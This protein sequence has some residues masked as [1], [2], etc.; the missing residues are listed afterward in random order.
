MNLRKGMGSSYL[1][2]WLAGSLAFA[3]TPP[4][5]PGGVPARGPDDRSL[6][7]GATP[8]PAPVNPAPPPPATPPIAYRL[9]PQAIRGLQASGTA[10]DPARLADRDTGTAF[11]FSGTASLAFDLEA[12]TSIIGIRLFGQPNVTMSIYYSNGQEWQP[13]PGLRSLGP[14]VLAP[15][16]NSLIAGAAVMTSSVRIDFTTVVPSA[17]EQIPEVEI[18]GFGALPVTPASADALGRIPIDRL[19]AQ[20]KAFAADP[21]E[22]SVGPDPASVSVDIPVPPARFRRAFLAYELDGLSTWTAVGRSINDFAPIGGVVDTPS[23]DWSTQVERINPDWLLQG[24]NRITFSAAD[25]T[26]PYRV[27][28]VRILAELDTGT[29]GV[30]SAAAGQDADVDRSQNAAVDGNLDTAWEPFAASAAPGARVALTLTFDRATWST[31]LAILL[32]RVPSGSLEVRTLADDGGVVVVGSRNGADLRAGWNILPLEA[33]AATRRM[34]VVFQMAPG[35][36]W[37]VLELVPVGSGIGSRENPPSIDVAWPV[38]GQFAGR[39]A[40]IRGFVSPA[41]DGSGP[42]RVTVG[43]TLVGG[44]RDGS[45]GVLVNKDDLGFVTDDDDTPW[46]VDIQAVYPS[47]TTLTRTVRLNRPVPGPHSVDGQLLGPRTF[48]VQPDK[49]RKIRY[50]GAGLDLDAGSVTHPQDLTITPMKKDDL[51][52]LDTG[53]TNV[54]KSPRRGYRFEPHGMRFAKSI[55]VTVPYDPALI[56]DGM[57]EKD[58]QTFYFDDQAGRWVPLDRVSLDTSAK[59]VTSLTDHFTDMISGTL[60]LPDHLQSLSYD[61][62]TMKKVQPANPASRIVLIEP[63]KAMNTGDAH[64]GYDLDLP[65]GRSGMNPH[66]SVT[67]SSSEGNGWLGLGWNLASPS[68]SIDTRWG[69]PRYDAGLETE[70]YILEGEQL[71]P[72]AHRGALVARAPEKTF[73]Y[74]TEGRFPRII[75]HGDAP[76]NYWWEATDTHGI[77]SAYG[78]DPATGSVDPGSTLA[79]DQGRIYRWFLH[80]VHDVHGNG[81]AYAY[82][83]VDDP[84]IVGGTVPGRQ[85]YLQTINYTTFGG[86]P[87]AFTVRMIR[88][89]DLGEPRRPDVQIDARGGFKMVTS[90]LLRRIEVTF[91]GAM[92][93]SWDLDYTRGAYEKSLLA[94]LTQRGSDGSALA[95]HRFSY[96]DDVREN[97]AYQGFAPVETWNTGSDGVR[98]AAVDDVASTFGSDAGKATALSG[99]ESTHVGGHLYVGFNYADPAKQGSA[100][101]KVGFNGSIHSEGLL[102]LIDLNGDDLPDKVFK[103]SSGIFA[104]MNA[105]GPHGTTV[106]GPPIRIDTLPAI[107][108]ESASMVSFGLESYV[109]VSVLANEALGFTSSSVYLSDVNGDGLPDLVDGDTVLFNHLDGNGVPSFSPDSATSPVPVGPAAVD[110]AGVTPDYGPQQQKILGAAPLLDTLRRWIAP[111][112]GQVRI[113]GD[114]SLNAPS[115]GSH[116]DDGVRV[117][118]QVDG[119]EL[120][121]ATIDAGDTSAHTPTGVDA[122]AVQKGD[123]IYFRVQ[124]RNEGSDDIVSWDPLIEYVGT[125]ATT[126]V[127]GLDPWHAR[128]SEDFVLAGRPGIQV[129]LPFNGKVFLAGDIH[130]NGVTTDDVTLLVLKNGQQVY[131]AGLSW[132]QTGTI[133]L[134]LAFDVAQDDKFQ[135]RIRVDS[136]I[137]LRQLDWTP[138]LYYLAP[139]DG[140]APTYTVDGNTVTVNRVVDGSGQ[141]L[142]QLHPAYDIDFY[143]QDGLVA[144]QSPWIAPGDGTV[145]VS[146]HLNAASSAT[147]VVFMTVKTHGGL[148]A[149][150]TI[151]IVNGSVANRNVDI[152]VAKGEALFFDY[153]CLDPELA[154]KVGN[155]V[156]KVD[157]NQVPSA[158]HSAA[159]QN[160]FPQSY[161]GWGAAGY[162]GN[163]PRDAQPIDESDLDVAF[164]QNSSVDPR[165]TNAFLFTPFPESGIW[166][167]PEDE[168]Y[169]SASVQSSS[170]IGPNAAVT[171]SGSASAAARAPIRT[172]SSDETAGQVGISFLSGSLST[173]SGRADIDFLDMNGD[174]FPDVIGNGRIQYSP[175]IGG[176]EPASRSIPGLDSPRK[177]D[178]TAGNVGVGGSPANF[179][180]GSRGQVDSP[181]R[182][183]SSKENNTGSQMVSLGLSGD[184]GSGSSSVPFDLLD[185]NGDGLPDRVST[186]GGT[187]TVAFNLGYAFASPEPWGAGALNE[188]GSESLSLG[189]NLGF[190][191]GIYDYGGGLS[192]AKN[193]SET[194]AM[195]VDINGDGLPDRVTRSG[196]AIRVG[197]NTGSGFLPDVDWGGAPQGAFATSESTSLGG[198]AYFTVGIGPVCL[199]GCWVILNPGADTSTSLARQDSAL[200]DVDGDGNV[201]HVTSSDDSLLTV[202]RNTAGRTNLLRSIARPLG[203]TID[204]DYDRAGNTTD[205]PRSRWVLSR[206]SIDDGVHGSGVDRQVVT[207]RYEN[208]VWDRLEREFYGYGRVT[209]EV[210]DSSN[211]DALYRATVR[212]YRTDS[213]YTRGLITRERLLDAAAR[214][215]VETE[216]TY[217]LRDA[218]TQLPVADPKSTTATVFPALV[219]TDRRFYEGSATPGKTTY[220]T[221]EFDAFGNVV[222]QLDVGDAGSQDDLEASFEYGAC[223]ATHIVSVPVKLVVKGNG[224][225]LRHREG[226]LDCATGEIGRITEFVTSATGAE[227]VVDHDE[228]GNVTRVLGPPNGN[229]QRYELKF[230]Y[231]PVVRS[232]PVR[233]T[234][235]FGYVSTA[236]WDV[237]QGLQ[238]G[239]TDINGNAMNFTYD[240]FGRMTSTTGPY[241]QGTGAASVV[242]QYHPDSPVPWSLTRHIDT[243]R[244]PSDPI[245]VVRFVDGLPRVIQEK[246]DATVFSGPGSGATDVMTVSGRLRFDPVGRITDRWYPV[247]EPL[248]T[249]GTFNATYDGIA[250]THTDYDVMDRSTNV[251]LP[252]LTATTY[253]YGFGAD[254]DGTQQFE[255]RTTDANGVL[256]IRYQ[257]VRDLVTGV[258]QFNRIAGGTQELWTSYGYDALKQLVQITDDRGNVTRIGWDNLGR[259]VFLD[260]PD[261]GRIEDTYDLASNRIARTTANLRAEARQITYGYEFTRLVSVLYPD[262]PGNDVTYTYGPPGA[263]ANRAG[264]VATVSDQSGSRVKSYGKLG[265]LT[266]E[267]RTIASATPSGP[268]IYETDY[269]YDTFNRLQRLVYPDGEVLTFSYDS[270][271]RIRA[272]SGKKA[273]YDYPYVRRMEYDKFGD[274]AF[275]EAGNGTR[276][277]YSYRPDNRRLDTVSAVHPDGS[278][279]VNRTYAY[280]NV[281]NVL[282]ATNNVPVAHGSDYGGPVQQTF[283]Y[284]DLERLMQS[285]GSYQF[286]PSKTNQYSVSFDYDTIHN[287]TSRS[288]LNE[289]VQPSGSTVR[290]QKTSYA[291]T[292]EYTSPHPHAA[293]H[294]GNRT[295][296]YDGNGNQAG[297]DDDRNGTRRRIVWDEVNDVQSVSDNGHEIDFAYDDTGERVIKRGPQGE[298]VYVNPWFTVR[299]GTTGSKHVW[300]GPLRIATK[301]MKQDRPGANPSGNT[302]YEKDQYFYHADHV[303]ST[304]FVTDAAGASYEHF[305]YFPFGETWVEE[306]SNK[307]RTPYGFTGN[308]LDEETG[309]YYFGA[310]YLDPRIAGFNA[311]EPLLFG[312]PEK[313]RDDPKFLSVYSYGKQ[314]PER[315]VDPDGRDVIIVVGQSHKEPTHS[316]YPAAATQLKKVLQGQNIKAEILDF[317]K[318]K[319]STSPT[320]AIRAQADAIIARGGKVSAVVYI[321]H[322]ETS[323][324]GLLPRR[325][326]SVTV[327]AAVEA[328]RLGKGG[329]I[330]T[331]GCKVVV[332]GDIDDLKAQ[333]VHVYATTDRYT[334]TTKTG[335]VAL[336][337]EDKEETPYGDLKDLDLRD[338]TKEYHG[339]D[340]I[341]QESDTTLLGDV[342]RAEN[343]TK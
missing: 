231:D 250:P 174:Q 190:N 18:W 279:F 97:G 223:D 128:A 52:A 225:E 228:V 173:G 115:S 206:V 341:G 271:G 103:T 107:S 221:Q 188:G 179:R 203:A 330:Y 312:S 220:S 199:A 306:S 11:P 335:K 185:I 7:A 71:T 74:R 240:V 161:R 56:P 334:W 332:N 331:Y 264:R 247:T 187:L 122:V 252:D 139:P 55:R 60:A 40:Y 294:V 28:S 281:G 323:G 70:T 209:E 109:G 176:L 290:Q 216:N 149:K 49:A 98:S 23:Q 198:G 163:P 275:I 36:P 17:V 127:N 156:I 253:Q 145:T 114:A 105:S 276:T 15:G 171:P 277:T 25:P 340:V 195:L 150:R 31:G 142:I 61:P 88:D 181:G 3:S 166:R 86:Q 232:Y 137:D 210:R 138:Q 338:I 110:A 153:S 19:P 9:T 167:G 329:A 192:L 326:D 255:Q 59:T 69:V 263:P 39:E 124:S 64:T 313:G 303:G 315:Y 184:L 299:N 244:N 249:P 342:K 298:T 96:F 134:G 207:L 140:P 318:V 22:L 189:T 82:A 53:L 227:T 224:V 191:G 309:L 336:G 76:T 157:G 20:L 125:T 123:R 175:A 101:G 93:R 321:G 211:G 310:R 196:N 66:L 226:S 269:T 186:S 51:A 158:F 68:V 208:G 267:V 324:K 219:R 325:D 283:A 14:S 155:R 102:A 162:N 343:D 177:S 33:S 270:G 79:D 46:S 83:R 296:S 30:E 92:V 251:R 201:D 57:T 257:N 10:G 246:S 54:T 5:A 218:E 99:Y 287:L 121:S 113:S 304:N 288:Q 305:E 136:P 108:E 259:K 239:S 47:G 242:F 291:W 272:A 243:Y 50:D 168:T 234:D 258:K 214:P 260:S 112:P 197:L 317:S 27:R 144:P 165:S 229:N 205:Q 6:E 300:V 91:N 87:G 237:A 120:W 319:E 307:Q 129:S 141:P 126:D 322:G 159:H 77:T 44:S 164:D 193:S 63:P 78:G 245:D 213:Y 266:S 170:R 48:S 235:S 143:P 34:Q 328:A 100:G 32:S 248:G 130:K 75:R 90:Q 73:R 215:F 4:A 160:V 119:T 111:F 65:G 43:T 302:P 314:N 80:E 62:T 274:R 81:M 268:E 154:P 84:G 72:V 278:L 212:D 24:T 200:I 148:V 42:A 146:S 12:P 295:L 21:A 182:G 236:T 327:K 204:L 337:N 280:D 222:H 178:A 316:G 58:V 131:A 289:I 297:W 85:L 169:V 89:D 286:A 265:E 26:V 1:A 230:Q 202:A 94:A 282:A 13:F 194:T 16:W 238:T 241:E 37:D 285:R 67:Y 38:Q 273:S 118:I 180:T 147:G 133:P 8:A 35:A 95:T 333:G 293:A 292:Y 308:E 233:T 2:A 29:N 151:D 217:E 311:T 116:G 117:A 106:F 262:F 132:D 104:R 152:D 256:S 135:L 254:R 172:T 45:F 320:D 284:D 301:L 261:E 41:D 183:G 339:N